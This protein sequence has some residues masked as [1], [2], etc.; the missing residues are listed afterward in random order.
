[1]TTPLPIAASLAA[2]ALILLL[3]PMSAAASGGGG[4]GGGALP[5]S[6]SAPSYDPAAEYQ[7]GLAALKDGKFKDAERSFGNALSVDPKNPDTLFMLGM[8]RAGRGDEKGAAKAYDKS[9]SIDPQQ[10][11]ARREYAVA[12]AKLGQTDKAQAQ[13][14]MLQQKA[15]SCAGSCPQAA[16]LTAALTAAQAA[17]TP[18]SAASSSVPAAATAPQS[19][20]PDAPAPSTGA[21]PNPTPP[22]TLS[23]LLTDPTSGDGS[24]VDAVRLINLHRYHDAL[25][26]LAK[27]RVAFGPHPDVLTYTGYAWRKLGDYAR[28]EAY[29]REALAIAPT[30]VGA[31]EYYGELMVERGDLAGARRMLARI[32]AVCTF[33]CVE[34]EDLRRWIEHGPPAS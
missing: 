23:L 17:M 14:A 29:Y 12:L 8:A 22:K 20:T 10:V 6:I 28:A 25:D 24:Y 33:G 9:L 2:G 18:P 16:E 7:R 27:A 34:S 31:T 32:E 19:A 1:M 11:P 5:P 26:S 3:T 21:P 30:H 15:A 4:L 13:L